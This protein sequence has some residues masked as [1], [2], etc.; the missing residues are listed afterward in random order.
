MIRKSASGPLLEETH[1]YPFGLTMVG[2]SSNALKGTQYSKN[3]K[4]FNGIEHTT[5]LDLNQYDAFYRNL[6]P[7]IGRWW[8]IDPKC[9]ASISE[10]P[11]V[12]MGNNP[13]SHMDPL[14]DYF[15]GLFGSTSAQRRAAREVAEQTGGEVVNK[16]SRKIHVNY[17]TIEKTYSE[18]AGAVINTAVGHTVNFR[19]NGRVHGGSA[20]ANEYIDQQAA[21]WSSHRVD[22][23]GN[24]QF[25]RASGRADYVPVESLLVPLPPVAS[26]LGRVYQASKA[27]TLFRAVS[28]AELADIAANGLRTLPGG[29]E[30]SKLFAT[31]AA[32]AA[33]FG[34][35]NFTFDGIANTIIQVKVPAQTMRFAEKRVLDGYN[36]V[37]VPSNLLNTI[38][39]IKPL[40]YSP[41]VRGG[42]GPF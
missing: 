30:S 24:I 37:A 10:S 9:E 22:E 2:I 36:G 7:Q 38:K 3:R 20:V 27:T 41:N 18:P 16:T 33:N 25:M 26:L 8:Q 17:T 14:G 5:D 31:T 35:N 28:G 39:T 4:E 40:N 15:F 32:D 13:I 23:N 11:Y 6:D 12:S 29:Y 42:W 19:S 1:Y 34:R 21:Y